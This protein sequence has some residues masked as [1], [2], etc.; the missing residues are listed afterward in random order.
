MYR[1]QVSAATTQNATETTKTTATTPFTVPQGVSRISAVGLQVSSDGLTTLEDTT[2]I[3]ELE[4]SDASVWDGTQQFCIQGIGTCV[5]SGAGYLPM[6]LVPTN[7][8][9]SPGSHIYPS[10]TFNS[11]LTVNPLWR[12]QLVFE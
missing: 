1:S 11:P 5:T 4:S 12:C 2:A 3:L 6:Q 10:V 8:R 7:I 9:V